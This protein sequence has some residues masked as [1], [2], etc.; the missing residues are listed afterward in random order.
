MTRSSITKS[1]TLLLAGALL[2]A[3]FVA[4]LKAAQE[5]RK[6]T[7]YAFWRDASANDKFLYLMGYAD[8]E[9]MYRLALDKGAKP[10]CS[11]AGKA[12]IED[13]DRKLP[14]PSNVTFKQTTQGIDDFYKD[15][16]NQSVPLELA[17]TVVRLQIAGRPQ[18]EIVEAIRRAREA[19]SEMGNHDK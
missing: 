4:R 12:W 6:M 14:V 10:L 2:G 9:Q 17:Q 11:E 7:G 13:F 16:K 3:V 1:L 5:Y 19:G 18:A 8:A 15:W